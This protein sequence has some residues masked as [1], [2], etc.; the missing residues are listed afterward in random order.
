MY[1]PQNICS[2]IQWQLKVKQQ[3]FWVQ[4]TD[5]CI[6]PLCVLKTQHKHVCVCFH[7]LCTNSCLINLL[8]RRD[9]LFCPSPSCT[10]ALVAARLHGP[11]PQNPFFV[12]NTTGYVSLSCCYTWLYIN[13]QK[14]LCVFRRPREKNDCHYYK[15]PKLS[16]TTQMPIDHKRALL[17]VNEGSLTSTVCHNEMSIWNIVGPYLF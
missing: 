1:M 6:S 17:S 16:G 12:I 13:T 10:T 3:L 14:L 2:S 11:T 9:V 8:M 4:C 5:M 15:S 7:P